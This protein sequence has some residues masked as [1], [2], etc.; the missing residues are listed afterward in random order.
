MNEIIEKID[1]MPKEN[2]SPFFS[3]LLSYLKGRYLQVGKNINVSDFVLLPNYQALTFIK[4]NNFLK[5]ELHDNRLEVTINAFTFLLFSKDVILD[6]I[7]LFLDSCLNGL[8]VITNYENNK[9]KLLYSTIEWNDA[10]LSSFNRKER[11]SLFA[12]E[13]G[14]KEIEKG[15]K[16]IA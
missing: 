4:G 2:Y 14:V 12:K 16:Y 15:V 6:L 10:K 11:N 7:H 1:S 3:D 8:Y 5:I 13:Q 9:G